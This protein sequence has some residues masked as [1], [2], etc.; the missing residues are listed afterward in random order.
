ML[1]RILFK[2]IFPGVI[3]Y[4]L[5]YLIIVEDPMHFLKDRLFDPFLPDGLLVVL[6][7][8]IIIILPAGFTMTGLAH[9]GIATV[10]TEELPGQ[11][12][13]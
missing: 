6:F 5:E 10:T 1:F 2:I 8:D 11:K 12:V 3:D 13:V 9:H 7:A 4:H